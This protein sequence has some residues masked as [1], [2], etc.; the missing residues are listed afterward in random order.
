MENLLQLKISGIAH[1][2]VYLKLK[3]NKIIFCT[4]NSIDCTYSMCLTHKLLCN[5]LDSNL[6]FTFTSP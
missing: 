5:K 2:Q 1:K 3:S 4:Q 6:G